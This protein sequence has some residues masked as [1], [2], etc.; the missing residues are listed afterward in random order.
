MTLSTATMTATLMKSWNSSSI[1]RP[2]RAAGLLAVCAVWLFASGICLPL[3][4]GFMPRPLVAQEV[5][6]RAIQLCVDAN[7]GLDVA[8]VDKDGQLDIVAGRNWY[9]GP[10]F[11]SRPL[12]S[13]ADWNGYVESN[14]DFARDVDND[15]WVDVVAG[16]FLPSEVHWY[17]NPGKPGLERGTEWEQHLLA[18]TAQS[19]NE[20]SFMHDLDGDGN[21]EWI[22]NSWNGRNPINV[23]VFETADS[24]AVSVL[25]KYVVGTSGQGHG[26]GFGDINGDGRPDILTAT[27][28]YEAPEAVDGQSLFGQPW[29][30][31]ADWQ[32]GSASC[33]I[34]VH[35]VDG[36]GRND[37]VWGKGH[38]FGL[39]WWRQVDAE[40]EQGV[41]RLKFEEHTIDDRY[42]QVHAIELCDLDGDGSLELI[43][44]K[45]V[46]A[47][48]GNDPGGKEPPCLY[49]Y[50]W[51]SE[52][53]KF[54]RRTI[55][56]GRVGTG[57][58]IRVADLNSDSKP[59]IAV[60]GKSG[61]WVLLQK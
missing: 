38:D 49:Y 3:Q 20:I 4:F 37:M 9:A 25:K 57:L 24:S 52:S 44:G 42:S 14:G 19:Q 36:D 35:D 39:Y 30:F 34:L 26:M 21:P 40:L 2:V 32:L 23:W 18:D 11:V 48:N 27:G 31:H 45:R 54:D 43:A 53:K 13:I 16:S 28:W 6:F 60:A 22:T 55:D 15:G 33:P 59:D 12:R 41:T 17:R 46:R 51:D 5:Q 10:D 58:Q 8:D 61:T 1:W 50:A 56:E 47:H 29:Q 7:E